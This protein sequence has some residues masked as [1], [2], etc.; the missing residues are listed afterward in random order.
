MSFISILTGSEPFEWSPDDEQGKPSET[1]LVLQIITDDMD[2]ELRKAHT[3]PVLDKKSRRMIP[4]LDDSGYTAA[5]ID[6]A[7]VNWRGVTDARTG[8][9]IP[10]SEAMKR[11]IPERIKLDVLRL[12]AGKEGGAVVAAEAEKKR[13]ATISRL[14]PTNS[15]ISS[16]A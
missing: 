10:C 6:A 13:S 2:T 15:S 16:A 3:R 1:V 9:E 7:I 11:L 8:A 14:S 12:C 4:T 5:V